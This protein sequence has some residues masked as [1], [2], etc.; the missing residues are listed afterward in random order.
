[1]ACDAAGSSVVVEKRC[2]RLAIETRS[3]VR[4]V[5]IGKK[6]EA[7]LSAAFLC[8]NAPE[9]VQMCRPSA[10]KK[11]RESREAAG[12]RGRL[13]VSNRIGAVGRLVETIHHKHPNG[14]LMHMETIH[15]DSPSY[16]KFETPP[17]IARAS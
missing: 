2:C 11:E 15:L 12:H 5:S 3:K 14:H 9:G 8:A 7:V 16:Q 17:W 13:A 4:R 1:M 10:G 6:F